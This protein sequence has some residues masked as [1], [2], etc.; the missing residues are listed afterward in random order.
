MET[1]EQL[2]ARTR[3]SYR[4]AHDRLVQ[5]LRAAPD[6]AAESRFV[7][8]QVL[9]ALGRDRPRALR[10]LEQARAGFAEAGVQ[11]RVEEVEAWLRKHGVR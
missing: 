10:L 2:I 7:V 3:Q 6:E 9:W 5:R 1:H 4:E 8:A 11:G